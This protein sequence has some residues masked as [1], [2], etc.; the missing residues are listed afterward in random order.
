[1]LFAR[2]T[3]NWNGILRRDESGDSFDMYP[4]TRSEEFDAKYVRLFEDENEGEIDYFVSRRN[5]TEE[6]C[7]RGLETQAEEWRISCLNLFV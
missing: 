5:E 4:S 7:A 3:E 6:E 1:M 2:K